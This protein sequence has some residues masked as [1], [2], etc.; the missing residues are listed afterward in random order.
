MD[1]SED[2][3]ITRTAKEFWCEN[4]MVDVREQ[5]KMEVEAYLEEKP[6]APV[7]DVFTLLRG[8]DEVA[9]GIGAMEE[10][11]EIEPALKDEEKVYDEDDEES[12][13]NSE[14][15]GDADDDEDDDDGADGNGVPSSGRDGNGVPSCAE[16]NDERGDEGEG[17]KEKK[18]KEV[19][20]E[21]DAQMDLRHVW[22]TK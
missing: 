11:Q 12:D 1:G 20:A 16:E 4:N 22:P 18:K 3:L 7:E 10:G 15:G 13:E 19:I 2:H 17:E 9:G 21:D 8:Y 14:G 5:I 6:K